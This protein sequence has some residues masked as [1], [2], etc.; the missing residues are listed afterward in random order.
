MNK[1]APISP[2]LEAITRSAT[3]ID[4]PMGMSQASVV[5][6]VTMTLAGVSL[7]A[8]LV[9]VLGSWI[10]SWAATLTLTLIL[11]AI[12]LAAFASA[13]PGSRLRGSNAQGTNGP[14]ARIGETERRAPAIAMAPRPR[15]NAAARIEP[16]PIEAVEFETA[17]SEDDE[18]ETTA[19]RHVVDTLLERQSRVTRPERPQ[20]PE[21]RKST[22]PSIAH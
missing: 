19:V 15:K 17:I 16:T 3:P 11:T 7:L 14:A 8:T 20:T 4:R 18:Q 21:F 5:G 6:A 2:E 12:S 1:Q 10:P 13:R 9:L 22:R